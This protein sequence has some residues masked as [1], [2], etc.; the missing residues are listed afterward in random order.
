MET[1]KYIHIDTIHTPMQFVE[2]SGTPEPKPNQEAV[3]E[4]WLL[5]WFQKKKKHN[6]S[7]PLGK[8]QMKHDE[9]PAKLG[10]F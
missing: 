1:P 5:A 7:K 10:R 6:E 9:N 8:T 4:R 3:W 2:K